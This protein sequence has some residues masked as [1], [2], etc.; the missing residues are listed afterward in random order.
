MSPVEA[1]FFNQLLLPADKRLG[2][3]GE[4]LD[5]NELLAH[6]FLSTTLIP[7]K[8]FPRIK[9]KK[10]IEM[11]KVTSFTYGKPKIGMLLLKD[12]CVKSKW[13]LIPEKQVIRLMS[14]RKLIFYSEDEISEM[15]DGRSLEMHTPRKPQQGHHSWLDGPQIRPSEWRRDRG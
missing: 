12:Y 14:S 8:P 2:C 15:V 7:K 9:F 1:D 10:A 3:K 13:W 6:K 4:M 11:D 5:F